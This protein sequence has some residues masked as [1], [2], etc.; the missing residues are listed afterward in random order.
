MRLPPSINFSL[1]TSTF[2]HLYS[3][4]QW[5]LRRVLIHRFFS[6]VYWV[7]PVDRDSSESLDSYLKPSIIQNICSENEE[8]IQ[9]TKTYRNTFTFVKWICIGLNFYFN[10]EYL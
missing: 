1:Y 10:K 9:E 2:L 6:L 8:Q 7:Y 3:R 4:N 5:Q